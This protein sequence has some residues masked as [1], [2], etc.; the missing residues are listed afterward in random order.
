MIIE[1]YFISWSVR[2]GSA[3]LSH[4]DVDAVS[5]WEFARL[6]LVEEVWVVAGEMDDSSWSTCNWLILQKADVR[7]LYDHW[8]Q[9]EN[10][11]YK[12]SLTCVRVVKLLIEIMRRTLSKKINFDSK[13]FFLCIIAKTN[14]QSFRHSSHST[15]S[16]FLTVST[17]FTCHI[18]TNIWR[19]VACEKNALSI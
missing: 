9:E 10:R 13:T 14:I 4:G 2:D 5:R 19:R 8:V 11:T 17:I 1:I 15:S 12:S 18:K 6:L 16:H 7:R 3:V